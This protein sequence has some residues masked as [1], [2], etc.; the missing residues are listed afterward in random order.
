[1]LWIILCSVC[2]IITV[3]VTLYIMYIIIMYVCV[4]YCL[5]QLRRVGVEVHLDT[6]L[7]SVQGGGVKRHTNYT[8]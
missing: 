8:L 2:W 3:I 5:I 6:L 1:M 7:R 4:H